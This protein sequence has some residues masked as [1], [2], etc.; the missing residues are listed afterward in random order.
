MYN[1]SP[2]PMESL[3]RFLAKGLGWGNNI[4]H[5]KIWNRPCVAMEEITIVYFSRS[6]GIATG[7]CIKFAGLF[8][9]FR[10]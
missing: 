7:Y 6:N 5:P 2:S 4:G 9:G 3:S 8:N 1:S 10:I